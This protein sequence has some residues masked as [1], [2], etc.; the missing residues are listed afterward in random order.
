[1][2]S[3]NVV[4][5]VGA[6]PLVLGMPRVEVHALRGMP[7]VQCEPTAW[8]GRSDSWEDGNI[9]VGYDANHHVNHIG[10]GPGCFAL[11]LDGAPLWSP[12]DHPDPNPFL[13][14]R[15]PHP[16]ESL[17][18]LVFDGIGVTTTGYHDDDENDL[19]LTVYPRGAWDRALARSTVPNLSRYRPEP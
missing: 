14:E 9:Q 8:Q 13:L 2:R 6:V 17:G 18:I 16:R 19:A 15:D 3:F 4:P 5:F 10:F 1:M 11:T 7:Q 12:I